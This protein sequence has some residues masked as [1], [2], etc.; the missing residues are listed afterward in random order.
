M[1]NVETLLA[2]RCLKL[3]RDQTAS[4]S[5][6]G[7]EHLHTHPTFFL[8]KSKSLQAG[9]RPV[10][11]GVEREL[12]KPASLNTLH[13]FPRFKHEMYF[14][15]AQ[16]D[17]APNEALQ[18]SVLLSHDRPDVDVCIATVVQYLVVWEV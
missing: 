4:E 9:T 17:P 2:K 3:V 11:P 8:H 15:L 10:K 5:L 14:L 12:S 1:G 13:M 18:N 16:L 7:V 6:A